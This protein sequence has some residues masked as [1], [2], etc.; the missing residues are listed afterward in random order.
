MY[1]VCSCVCVLEGDG[2]GRLMNILFRGSG[3]VIRCS[4]VVVLLLKT[5]FLHTDVACVDFV[6]TYCECE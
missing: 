1:N 6:Y 3:A 5:L 2:G 4:F